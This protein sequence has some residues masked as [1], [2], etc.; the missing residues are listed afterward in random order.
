MIMA[1][2]D[3]G[4]KVIKC[5]HCGKVIRGQYIESDSKNYH[6][7]CYREHIALRC[8]LCGGTINGEYYEDYWGNVVHAEH[9]GKTAQCKYCRRFISEEISG[10]G[11]K[12]DDGREVCGICV[13]SAITDAVNAES[14]KSSVQGTLKRY[15]ISVED[16]EIPLFL[17]NKN[18]MSELARGFHADPLGFTHYEETRYSDGRRSDQKFKIYIL[19]GLPHYEFIG[20]LAHELMHAW[21]F[22][23]ASFDIDPMLREGSCNYAA[24]LVLKE[25]SDREAKFVLENMHAD[26]NPLYGDGFRRVKDFVERHK[27][28]HWLNYLMSNELPPW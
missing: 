21:L 18:A 3:V 27:V 17:V 10:G 6:H 7:N 23:N 28:P 22:S 13:Q 11:F 2:V 4:A 5:D 20:A 25:N 19:I 15:G 12:Y 26:S 14:I 1:V 24:Y 16:K 8:S 9:K